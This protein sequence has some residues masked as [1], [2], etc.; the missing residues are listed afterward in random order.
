MRRD[1]VALILALVVPVFVTSYAWA[2]LGTWA[3]GF[4]GALGVVS[5]SYYPIV[6]LLVAVSLR[7]MDPT[8]EETSRS[9]GL[10][11][12][13]TFTRVVVPQ[14][15]PALLGGL[16]LVALAKRAVPHLALD[17]NLALEVVRPPGTL[18]C[19]DDPATDDGILAQFRH[20]QTPKGVRE[21]SQSRVHRA[22][23]GQNPSAS[24]VYGQPSLALGF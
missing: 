8:L 19:D 24:E 7:V 6:F 18:V 16:L 20:R 9:L 2:N 23:R 11:A 22:V 10:G 21:T 4:V 1:G 5:F 17:V 13:A 12:W 14:L 3:Q 15:L